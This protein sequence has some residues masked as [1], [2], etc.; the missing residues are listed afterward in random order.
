MSLIETNYHEMLAL[1]TNEFIEYSDLPVF[2]YNDVRASIFEKVVGYEPLE[3]KIMAGFSHYVMNSEN[4][5][6]EPD[7]YT[8]DIISGILED[9]R[10]YYHMNADFDRVHRV[11]FLTY[12]LT[13][14][15]EV[16]K[17]AV[18]E[19]QYDAEN[20]GYYCSCGCAAERY[21]PNN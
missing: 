9:L 18:K 8:I 3:A 13:Y 6:G 5:S 7:Q 19:A 11:L 17:T 12:Y 2:Q 21:V 4:L 1:F 16:A 20:D 14:T 15:N 10:G